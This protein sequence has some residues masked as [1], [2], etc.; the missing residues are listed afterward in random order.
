MI[1]V[2]MLGRDSVVGAARSK[3]PTCALETMSCDCYSA[4]KAQQA[5]LLGALR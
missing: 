3:S 4:V 5:R 2:A 1:E